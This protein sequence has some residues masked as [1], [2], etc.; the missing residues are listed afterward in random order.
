ME[1]FKSTFNI[2]N[3]NT[4]MSNFANLVD[5]IKTARVEHVKNLILLEGIPAMPQAQFG[6]NVWAPLLTILMRRNTGISKENNETDILTIAEMLVER[7]ENVLERNSMG[8][9]P[10]DIA[11]QKGLSTVVDYL[12]AVEMNM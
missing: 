5:S 2:L 7:G 9:A 11:R 12:N 6:G 4:K 8:K 10:I 1:L 3:T